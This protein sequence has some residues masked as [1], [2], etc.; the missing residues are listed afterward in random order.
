MSRSISRDVVLDSGDFNSHIEAIERLSNHSY[1]QLQNSFYPGAN[2]RQ[3]KQNI[4]KTIKKIKKNVKGLKEVTKEIV[5]QINKTLKHNTTEL[6]KIAK[7]A[8]KKTNIELNE[9]DFKEWKFFVNEDMVRS[10]PSSYDLSRDD[11]A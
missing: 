8:N 3:Q 6:N 7:K 1:D 11:S 4:L 9:D 2:K 10:L 5:T